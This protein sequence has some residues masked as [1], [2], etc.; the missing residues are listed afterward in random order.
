MLVDRTPISGIGSNNLNSDAEKMKK[1]K[2]E[3]KREPVG[4]LCRF[5]KLD[6]ARSRSAALADLVLV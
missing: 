3:K 5:S 6:L 2:E 1:K 4:N